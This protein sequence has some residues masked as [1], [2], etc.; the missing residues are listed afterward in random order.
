MRL[1]KEKWFKKNVLQFHLKAN[2]ETIMY[3]CKYDTIN[4]YIDYNFMPTD[5]AKIMATKRKLSKMNLTDAFFYA[6]H[7]KHNYPES[8]TLSFVSIKDA[9]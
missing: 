6:R 4:G 9:L 3:Y 8:I 1:N 5:S 7:L 2:N